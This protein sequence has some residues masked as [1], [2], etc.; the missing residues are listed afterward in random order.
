MARR[1]NDDVHFC[2]L[3]L[4][5]VPHLIDVGQ[6][7]A[8]LERYHRLGSGITNRIMCSQAEAIRVYRTMQVRLQTQQ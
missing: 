5:E 1:A 4:D 3:A 8:L 2:S 7:L 6:S